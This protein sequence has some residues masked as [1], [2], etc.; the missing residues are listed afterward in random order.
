MAPPPAQLHVP[1]LQLSPAGHMVPQVPQFLASVISF[2]QAVPQ[3]FGMALG[4]HVVPLQ[5]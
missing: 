5:V 2:V 1:P 4:Q 3:K